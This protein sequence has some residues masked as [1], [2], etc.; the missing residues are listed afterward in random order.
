LLLVIDGTACTRGWVDECLWPLTKNLL[1]RDRA[2]ETPSGPPVVRCVMVSAFCPV[3]CTRRGYARP[4]WFWHNGVR[5]IAHK[6]ANPCGHYQTEA[7]LL[8]E[9]ELQCAREHCVLT[10]SL[11]T[12]YPYCSPEC[13]CEPPSS[14]PCPVG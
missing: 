3:C 7:E 6:W 14:V 11:D 8:V 4:F 9:A 5:Y 2:A 1:I 12:F 13:A 10:A